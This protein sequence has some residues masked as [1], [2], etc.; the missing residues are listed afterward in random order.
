MPA[1]CVKVPLRWNDFDALRHVNNVRYHEFMQDGRVALFAGM[2]LA[3][4]YLQTIGH[5]VARTEIDYLAPIPM[6]VSEID[7]EIWV[8][9]IGGASYTLGYEFKSG[10]K[11]FAK[12]RTVMVTVELASDTVTRIPDDIRIKLAQLS[13]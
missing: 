12:A 2:G 13:R 4:D 1:L 11:L 10:E 3:R 7:L 6:D 8:E 5:F 9:K